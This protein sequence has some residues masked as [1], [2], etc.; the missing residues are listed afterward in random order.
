MQINIGK[1]IGDAV[2]K[3]EIENIDDFCKSKLQMTKQNYYRIIKKETIHT[4]LLLRFCKALNIDFFNFYYEDE[5]LYSISKREV[6]K[7]K[8]EIKDLNK[9]IERKEDLII[10]LER[11]VTILKEE[12]SELKLKKGKR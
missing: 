10:D 9:I 12:N 7:L 6:E 2:D 8:F 1:I 5:F 4:D 3:S 11:K